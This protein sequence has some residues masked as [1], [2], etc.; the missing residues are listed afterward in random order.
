MRQSQD[1]VNTLIIIHSLSL[2]IHN[3]HNNNYNK[4]HFHCGYS[5]ECPSVCVYVQLYVCCLDSFTSSPEGRGRWGLRSCRLWEQR[6]CIPL[7]PHRS[8]TPSA[9]DSWSSG[10]ET[11]KKGGRGGDEDLGQSERLIPDKRVNYDMVYN[12][13]YFHMSQ[14]LVGYCLG[15]LYLILSAF[16]CENLIRIC[17]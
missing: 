2:K 7:D 12:R 1:S 17:M 6:W 16:W 15:W 3:I 11:D 9:A 13:L 5:L 4:G 8:S 14:Y 10:T